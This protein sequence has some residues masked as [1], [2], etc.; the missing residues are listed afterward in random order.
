MVEK[1]DIETCFSEELKWIQNEDLRDKVVNVWKEA[2]DR[3][4]WKKIDDAPFIILSIF[5]SQLPT[6]IGL[7]GSDMSIILR[8][9]L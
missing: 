7:D 9:L 5:G 4:H 1:S 3:G 6:V 8:P 2:S